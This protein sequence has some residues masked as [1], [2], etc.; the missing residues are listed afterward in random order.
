MIKDKRNRKIQMANDATIKALKPDVKMIEYTEKD[1][2]RGTG[3][4]GI[5][6]SS[7]GTKSWFFMYKFKGSKQQKFNFGTYP[8]ISDRKSVV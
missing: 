8:E 1:R 6:V 7:G 3:T 4:F 2:T 5:R